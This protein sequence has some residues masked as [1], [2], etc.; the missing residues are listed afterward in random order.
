MRYETSMQS[1]SIVQMDFTRTDK[2]G[3]RNRSCLLV[4]VATN[5]NKSNRCTSP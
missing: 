1:P 5:Y 2:I 4:L 3:K